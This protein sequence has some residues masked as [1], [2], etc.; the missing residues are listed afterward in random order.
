M[1]GFSICPRLKSTICQHRITFL[2]SDGADR[3]CRQ[4]A[5]VAQRTTTA[6]SPT[7]HLGKTQC[8]RTIRRKFV[9][10]VPGDVGRESKAPREKLGETEGSLD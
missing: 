8:S 9:E 6:S 3:E 10:A 2:S 5:K 1:H 4:G 7:E